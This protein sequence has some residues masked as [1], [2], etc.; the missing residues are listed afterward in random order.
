[1]TS[2]I[3]KGF[4]HHWVGDPAGLI[5]SWRPANHCPIYLFISPFAEEQG[6]CRRLQY[7]I[8]AA[9]AEQGIN[10]VWLDLPGTGDSPIDETQMTA[11]MWHETVTAAVDWCQM[12]GRRLSAIGGLRLGGAVA[13]AWSQGQPALLKTLAIEPIS[14]PYAL[15][16]LL[17]TQLAQDG[18]TTEQLLQM[19]E[20]GETIEAAGYPL[21]LNSK[22]TLE[23]FPML[24]PL[25]ASVTL[26]RSALP[27]LPPWLQVEPKD[28]SA[29]ALHLGRQLVDARSRVTG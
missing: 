23:Q 6:R 25:P 10:G 12:H 29:L 21:N 22:A 15:R 9:L 20:N 13:I 7:G 14:G 16:A 8:S 5:C 17:R 19:I 3:P 11:A 24:D 28:A 26:I 2:D 1:L 4:D 18:N 27:E